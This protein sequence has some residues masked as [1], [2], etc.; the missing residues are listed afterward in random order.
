ME[1]ERFSGRVLWFNN[2][3]G[4]GFIR[5]DA[6]ADLF[7]HFSGIISEG[8]K[9]LDEGDEVEYEVVPGANGDPKQRAC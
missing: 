4:Y 1:A 8:Y 9:S 7:V 5:R 6:A 2:S 3:K